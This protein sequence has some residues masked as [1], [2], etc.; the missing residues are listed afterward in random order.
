MESILMI[1]WKNLC[2]SKIIKQHIEMKNSVVGKSWM[3][4]DVISYYG[5]TKDTYDC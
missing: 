3:K 5:Q 2:V 4:W 1:R